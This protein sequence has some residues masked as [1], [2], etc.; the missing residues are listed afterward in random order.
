VVTATGG[1]VDFHPPPGIQEAI[2]KKRSQ[3]RGKGDVM[4]AVNLGGLH[5]DPYSW[6]MQTSKDF[7]VG[8]SPHATVDAPTNVLGVLAFN[9]GVPGQMLTLP[10]WLPNSARS[11]AD[12]RLL[13]PVLMC[14]GWPGVSIGGR[15]PDGLW[16]G[17]RRPR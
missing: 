12:P 1:Y 9:G 16:G 13:Q 7:K 8:A 3:L 10:I 14:L 4:L 15:A 11:D 6:S 17:N 5:V 2:E